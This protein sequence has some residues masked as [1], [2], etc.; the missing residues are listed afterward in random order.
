[1][2]LRNLVLAPLALLLAVFTTLPVRAFD[3]QEVTSAG[4]IKAYLVESHA[5]P[6]ISIEFAFD[7]GAALDAEGKE[8]TAQFLTG[9]MDEGADDMTGEQ[10]R[11]AR[12]K[13]SMRLQFDT[14]SD[15]F[16]VSFSTLSQH[17]DEAFA[18][19][20][21]TI[22][23]PRLEAEPIERMRA[24]FMQ[25][26]EATDRDQNSIAGTDEHCLPQPRL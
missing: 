11:R 22:T 20:H 3:I 5:I 4:G 24:Y 7:G 9:L 15:N 23:H 21:K 10:W 8:G 19:L 1:M 2:F 25:S 6:L 26:V 14:G 17:A 13:I 12:D 18:L 16:Y